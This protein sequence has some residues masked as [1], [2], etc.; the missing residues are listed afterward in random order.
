M[1]AYRETIEAI[2]AVEESKRRE[3]SLPLRGDD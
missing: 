2:L 3:A 1:D